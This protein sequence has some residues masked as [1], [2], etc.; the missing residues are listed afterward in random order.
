M[1]QDQTV[2]T[3]ATLS[4][5]DASELLELFAEINK[6]GIYNV[7]DCKSFAITVSNRLYYIQKNLLLTL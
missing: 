2:E 7:Y 1:T 4:Q 6:K 3:E 5:K